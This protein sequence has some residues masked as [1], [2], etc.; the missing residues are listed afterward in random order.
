MTPSTTISTATSFASYE[1]AS[2][3]PL[4]NS[5]IYTYPD[6]QNVQYK[7]YCGVQFLYNDLPSVNVASFTNCIGACDAY[8]PAAPGNSGDK[9][10]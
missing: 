8:V 2:P 1:P 10:R 9:V 4:Q 5:S 7:I 6:G 3:C